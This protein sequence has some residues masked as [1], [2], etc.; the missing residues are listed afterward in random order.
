MC[1]QQHGVRILQHITKLLLKKK[2]Q[3]TGDV[4]LP[5][6]EFEELLKKA[7]FNPDFQN[8]VQKIKALVS[9]MVQLEV[10]P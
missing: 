3:T 8:D 9:N 2:C 7:S 6:E 10:C 5:N 1:P 4:Y